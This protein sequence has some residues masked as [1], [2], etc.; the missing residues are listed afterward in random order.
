MKPRDILIALAVLA[1]TFYFIQ[2]LDTD[3]GARRQIE[4]FEMLQH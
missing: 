1:A 2:I 3:R 4:N